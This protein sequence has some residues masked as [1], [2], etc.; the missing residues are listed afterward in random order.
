MHIWCVALLSWLQALYL[1]FIFWSMDLVADAEASKIGLRFVLRCGKVTITIEV[2]ILG[3]SNLHH[4]CIWCLALHSLLQVLYLIQFLV[5]GL[6]L[7]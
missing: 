4:T 1:T 7:V 5:Y 6:N 3:Y 2:D